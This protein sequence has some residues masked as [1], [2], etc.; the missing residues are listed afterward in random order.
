MK[1]GDLVKFTHK[2]QKELLLGIITSDCDWA[3]IEGTPEFY[4]NVMWLG[5]AG[6]RPINIKFLEIINEGG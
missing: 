3:H 1:I 2:S 5:H 6:P 4:K